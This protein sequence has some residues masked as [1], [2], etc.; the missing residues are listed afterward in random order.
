MV[1]T[2]NLQNGKSEKVNSTE[3]SLHQRFDFGAN[4]LRFLNTLNEERISEAVVSLQELLGVE[5]LEGKSFLDIGSGSGLS[6]LAARRL[7]ASVYS[8]DYD[9][10]SV[11]CTQKVKNR[12]Y[13]DDT[14]W[15]VE[16]GSVLDRDYLA[17]LGSFDVVY[18]WGVLHHTGDMLEGL[19]NVTIAL[20]DQGLL[21]V[22]IYN[23]QDIT[24]GFWKR[25]KK[26]YC[27]S[28][29]G[30]FAVSSLFLP[31]FL[32]QGIVIGCVKYRNPAGY[33][34]HYKKKRGMSVYHDWIDWL[35]G[36]PFEVAKPEE[37]IRFYTTQGCVLENL[38][39]TNRLGCNQF[40]F[41]KVV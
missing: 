12:Y 27:S 32:V 6:S 34:I 1:T 36:Y 30:K 8:F 5:N 17:S 25:I 33:F 11:G 19:H 22:A 24:S 10:K 41:R 14:D 3:F 2:C 39:T 13:P 15:Y 29:V 4:W 18:S 23:D 7:G 38:I 28:R 35:G 16:Q 20:P 9:P 26:M 37:I 40:V 31:L 21:C